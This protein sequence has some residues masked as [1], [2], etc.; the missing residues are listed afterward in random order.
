VKLV[1][2]TCE[3]TPTPKESTNPLSNLTE[4]TTQPRNK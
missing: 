3:T 2:L 1:S 4:S